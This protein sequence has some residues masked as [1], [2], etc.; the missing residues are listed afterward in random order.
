[1]AKKNNKKK[2]VAKKA[3]PKA[4]PKADVVE[5]EEVMETDPTAMEGEVE[6]V[7]ET[8]ATPVETATPD[9]DPEPVENIKVPISKTEIKEAE[10]GTYKTRLFAEATQLRDNMI[11]LKTALETNKV[12]ASEVEILTEQYNVMHKLA[13]ILNTRL[14]R[15]Q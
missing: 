13:V 15:A 8:E 2:T 7:E 1:M 10:E 14:G 9:P 3:A 6:A 11:K 5:V 12:P 4:A